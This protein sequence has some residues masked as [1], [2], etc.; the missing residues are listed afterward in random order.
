MSTQIEER[1]IQLHPKSAERYAK[2]REVFPDGVTHDGRRLRPFSLFFTH[3][4]GPAKWDV[5][6]N[7]VLDYFA[8]HGALILG[9]SNPD[10][11]EAVTRQVSMATHLG[12]CGDMENEWG[13]RIKSLIPSAE[14]VRFT[15]SGTE[16]TMMALKLV[17]AYTGKSKIIKFQEH[18]HGW[19]DYV[20]IGGSDAGG[21]PEETAQ[22]MI[23]LPPNDIGIVAQAVQDNDVAAIILEPTGAHMGAEP[24]TPAFLSE[25]RELTEKEGV[26]L[27]FDEVVTGF[28]TSSGGAQA[29]YGV[30]PDVTTLAKILAGGLPGGGV[31]GKADIINMIESTGD[32]QHDAAHRV[33]HPGTFNANPL[34][35][36]A[37]AKGLELI[38]TTG[39][40][41]TVDAMGT[42]LRDG[43]NDVLSRM[44]ITGCASGHPSA[45][46]L[47]L[48]L[49][50][51]CDGG[52]MCSASLEEMHNARNGAR[53]AQLNLALIN[54]GVQGG[55][56]FLLTASHSE[57]DIDNTVAAME[58][59]LQEVRAEGL[60]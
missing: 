45:V 19:H 52:V 39:V 49:D 1:F 25:L 43:L 17:R 28:R 29:Y 59:A 46:F 30:T 18:F 31:A 55:S 42:R 22:T 47:R 40:N 53:D 20:V 16:A 12:G 50:H 24:V 38:E 5:D 44:E 14:R 6:G 60:V 21:V 4:E 11:V 41:D 48:G 9:H 56:R 51:E 10:I 8:G 2:S 33:A 27:I 23:V 54:H 7:R 32:R 37:G 57:L 34:S 36:A 26:V 35:A 3:A 15:S 58:V 13:R